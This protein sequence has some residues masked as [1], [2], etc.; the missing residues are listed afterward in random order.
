MSSPAANHDRLLTLLDAVC[1]ERAS[2]A[3]FA[4]IERLVR[5]DVTARQLYVTYLDLHGTLQWDACGGL[6]ASQVPLVAPVPVRSLSRRMLGLVVTIAASLLVV[7][8]ALNFN[9]RPVEQPGAPIAA[10]EPVRVPGEAPHGVSPA[11][12]KPIHLNPVDVAN[13]NPV[14]GPGGDPITAKIIEQPAE[15]VPPTR[16]PHADS[17]QRIVAEVNRLLVDSWKRLDVVPAPVA[18]ETEWCRRVHLDL[19]GRIPAVDEVERF[20]KDPSTD[21]RAR[22]VDRLLDSGEF[23]RHFAGVWGRTLIGR[24]P[25]D[26]VNRE[27]FAKFLRMGFANNRPWNVLVSDMLAADGKTDENGA[28]NF[29]VAH[30]NNQAVPATAITARVFLGVQVQCAQCHD[31]PF[32]DMKQVAFWEL[33]SVFQQTDILEEHLRDQRT[34]RMLRSTAELVSKSEGGPIYYETQKGLMK[35]AFPRF[36]GR[37][38]DPSPATNRRQELARIMTEGDQP[39]LAAAFVNR[40]WAHLIGAGFT[41]PV[42]DMGPHNPP[43]HPELLKAL[44]DEFLR[45]GYDVKQLVRVICASEAYQLS[46]KPASQGMTD[47][48]SNGELPTFA[49]TYLKPMSP[50]QLYDSLIT[51]TRVQQT[52]VSNW[53]LAEKQRQTWMDQFVVSLENDENDEQETLAGT[54][55]QALQMMNGDLME[56]ALALTPQTFLGSVVRNKSSEADKIRQLCVAALSR[57]PTAKELPAMQKLVRENGRPT[58]AGYQ[59][60]L[61]ALLNTNEFT[62]VH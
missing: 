31:H 20:L 60:L 53:E 62:L 33:N 42:D 37:V 17:Q 34:G 21:K 28:A 49:R 45:S 23:A 4:E 11:T 57:P 44:A 56:K 61:W 47:D 16:S 52:G 6:S 46:T 38:I 35:V 19:V 59:D 8:G 54:Y 13:H 24:M 2:A 58:P 50:E 32:N 25:N 43:S 30:L 36:E 14:V 27:S 41:R 22:L 55:A 12:K 39:Q 29:L 10:V 7:V 5:G 51:A 40:L 48:P 18:E 9:R 1:D 26:R 15:V 3:D